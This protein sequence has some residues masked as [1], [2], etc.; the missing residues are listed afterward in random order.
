ML[1]HADYVSRAKTVAGI[2]SS[3][4]RMPSTEESM[5]NHLVAWTRKLASIMPARSPSLQKNGFDIA[6]WVQY[7]TMDVIIELVFGKEQG[8]GF[9]ENGEDVFDLCGSFKY[10]LP[11]YGIVCRMYPFFNW[12]DTTLFG[13]FLDWYMFR[14]DDQIGPLARF[15]HRVLNRRLKVEREGQKVKEN[16][17]LQSYAYESQE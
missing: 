6:P 3:R 15:V 8:L 17:M 10:G 2:Y 5:D 11:I 16:D 1:S 4:A 13:R 12:L 7:L 9:V 14:F